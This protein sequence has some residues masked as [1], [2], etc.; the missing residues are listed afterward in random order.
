MTS[1]KNE[2]YSP[3]TDRMHRLAFSTLG[4]QVLDKSSGQMKN[5]DGSPLF[6]V[7][8]LSL[9]ASALAFNPG[10]TQYASNEQPPIT[11]S[12]REDE[13]DEDENESTTL[14]NW[15]GTHNIEVTNKYFHHPET[16]QQLESIVKKSHESQIPIRPLG[17]ALSP[18]GVGFQP[19]G[20]ISLAYLDQIINVDKQNMTVTVQAGARVSQVIDALRAHGMTLPNLASIAE[21]Q[22][23]GFIQVGAHGT[24]A[25]IP[26]VDEF[27]T[28]LKLVTPTKGTLEL[29]KG[30]P[31]FHLAKVGLGCLGVV[32][33]ITMQCIPA[34]NLVE[35]TYVLTRSEAKKQ[36]NSLLKKH[37]HIRYMW[38]PYE[39][40]VVVVTNDPEE[41]FNE[42]KS[43]LTE[44]QLTK[45]EKDAARKKQFEPLTDLL[46]K[47]TSNPNYKGETLSEELIAGM[48]FGELRDAL[49]AINPLDTE[50]VKLCNVAEAKFWKNSEGF[51]TKPSDQ[52]LQF[53][54]G[55]QQ[56]VWEVCFPT[57]TYENNNNNDM[58]FMENLLKGIEENKIAAHSPIE[59]RWTASSSSEMSPAHGP[60]EGLHCWVGIIMYLPTDQEEQRNEIT[61]AFK[62][63]YCDL[64]RKV[65]KDFS[66]TSHWA[67]LEMPKNEKE[68]EELQ[69]FMKQRFPVTE[70]NGA[71]RSLDDKNL[72]ANDLMNAV[73]G[74]TVSDDDNKQ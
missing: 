52:L 72:L 38:I 46:L 51:Q 1:M 14:L 35:H 71:R 16:T 4:N 60:P 25:L 39:D 42:L 32:S 6:F 18:N 67:K 2:R 21:Q 50:H 7:A 48:G 17:S 19:T 13:H 63:P 24:G 36:I 44:N 43:P 57:G 30:D 29:K 59:Q 54:C 9:A 68:L 15:S 23:G 41:N 58:M 69:K 61:S 65:G 20:M 45:E 31:L 12:G 33:E 34:H 70:F 47:F 3:F 56:W 26:P 62:G 40:A 53:D 55:G 11:P 27:V 73:F 66:A 22:M 64:M 49:L 8:A 74:S 5:K 28:N 10:V 37:K